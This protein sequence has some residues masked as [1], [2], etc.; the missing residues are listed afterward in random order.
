[1]NTVIGGGLAGL[2]AAVSL[3]RRGAQVRLLEQSSRL[4][5]RAITSME[6]GFAMNL[7]PHALYRDGHAYR[8]LR[9]WGIQVSGTRPGVG[10]R[11]FFVLQDRL[12]PM[13]RDATSMLFSSLLSM[14]EKLDAANALRKLQTATPD[15]SWSLAQWMDAEVQTAQ[16]RL[17]IETLAR[18]STYSNAPERTQALAVLRQIQMATNGGVLYLDGGWQST[19]DALESHARQLGVEI[20]QGVTTTEV[21]QD[22]ILAIPPRQVTAITGAQFTG[23]H[24]IRMATL[25]LGLSELPPGAADFALGLD[26]PL[27]YSVHSKWARLARGKRTVVHVAKYLGDQPGGTARGELEAFADLLMP[28]WRDRV[29]IE[30]FLPE[31][32]VTHTGYWTDT[33]RPRIDE[34]PGALIAGDWVGSEGMLL[35]ASFASA[36][37]AAN[38]AWQRCHNES[39]AA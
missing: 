2:A 3:A 23:L 38:L 34:V 21:P 6:Q 39:K 1:M 9:N 31:M 28:G 18:V 16:V 15:P 7:G 35:D 12:F 10:A 11:H 30:R 20:M 24:P 17:V 13:F 36:L 26:R 4:G 8:T 5:G 25:D 14:R 32:T 22:S 33:P 29:E 37:D 27:Y 19:V